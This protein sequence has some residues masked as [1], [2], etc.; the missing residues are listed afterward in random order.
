[1]EEGLGK[2]GAAGNSRD[3]ETMFTSITGVIGR[4]TM[5]AGTLRGGHLIA[6]DLNLDKEAD[7][8]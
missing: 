5:T 1:M 3:G 4:R 7:R 2:R 6:S 8:G